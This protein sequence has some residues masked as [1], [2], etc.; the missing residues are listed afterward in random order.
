VDGS[1]ARYHAAVCSALE[2]I[3]WKRLT[4]EMLARRVVGALDRQRVADLLAEVAEVAAVSL[5]DEPPLE[6]VDRTDE[7]VAVLVAAM[8]SF[9]WRS[10]TRAGLCRQLLD[11]LDAWWL[12]RR[13][14]AVEQS[15][16]M[17]GM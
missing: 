16:L 2:P 10:L 13:W 15:W 14:R 17:P 11:A 12:S 7:R 9:Q 5:P 1:A 3:A 4:A 6:L 8:A